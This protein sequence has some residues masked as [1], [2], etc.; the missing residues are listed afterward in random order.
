MHVQTRSPDSLGLVSALSQCTWLSLRSPLS[1]SY[2]G[3]TQSRLWAQSFNCDC[4]CTKLAHMG[5]VMCR[6]MGIAEQMGRVLQRTS[7]SVNIKERLD[8][9]CALFGPDG[10][11]SLSQQVIHHT[12]Q[13][14]RH[15]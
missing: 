2:V 15:P 11:P 10:K 12:Q 8:F 6:F 4:D 7:I 9:S 13:R 5:A 14:H 3:N 1:F